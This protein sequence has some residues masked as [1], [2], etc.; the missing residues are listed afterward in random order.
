MFLNAHGFTVSTSGAGSSGHE[1]TTL[2]PK[3]VSAIKKFQEAHASQVL[4]PQGLKKG[5]GRIGPATLKLIQSL[6]AG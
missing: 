5:N 2:G 1:T 3:T 6:I 4:V